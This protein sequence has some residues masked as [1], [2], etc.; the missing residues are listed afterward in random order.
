VGICGFGDVISWCS[1]NPH[2]FRDAMH[3]VSTTANGT[4][5]NET[6]NPPKNQFG[7]QAKNLASVIRGF[8]IGVTVN[9][10]KIDANFAWQSRYHDHI[11]RNNVSFQKI[12][13]Y[14]IS[15]TKNWES[16]KFFN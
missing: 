10:R 8:K 1:Y 16:D 12:Q 7:P 11:I 9:A 13:D 3:C 14:I 5:A 6:N 2:F 4:N 15:N